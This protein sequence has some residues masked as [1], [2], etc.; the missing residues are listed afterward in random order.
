MATAN[1]NPAN[2][3]FPMAQVV[4]FTTTN[5]SNGD[6]F[7][8][9]H[10]VSGPSGSFNVPVSAIPISGNKI[11]IPLTSDTSAGANFLKLHL[12][13]PNSSIFYVTFCVKN[14]AMQD[15]YYD[16]TTGIPTDYRTDFRT[17]TRDGATSF[18][19]GGATYVKTLVFQ[20]IGLD[21]NVASAAVQYTVR[22]SSVT[23]GTVGSG[24]VELATF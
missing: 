13:Q 22:L 17:F 18:P 6:L 19:V 7:V 3:G 1:Q 14:N 15:G 9:P 10:T 21:T 4:N 16:Y 12:P 2:I 23:T 20:V 8:E 5:L 24:G 11:V